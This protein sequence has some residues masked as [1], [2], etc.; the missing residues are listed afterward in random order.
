MGRSPEGVTFEQTDLAHLTGHDGA[1]DKAFAVN[2]NLFWTGPADP[3]LTTLT[4][5]LR[6]GGRLLLVYEGP[7]GTRDVSPT[8]TANL[9]RHGFA[10]DVV[11]HPVVLAISAVR[12]PG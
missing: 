1:F 6:P 8:I 10:A 2:V 12:P 3:E 7:G 9:A 11:P 4:R 5:V